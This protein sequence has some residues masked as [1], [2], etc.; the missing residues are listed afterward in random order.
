MKA[1]NIIVEST[2]LK[3]VLGVKLQME[4]TLVHVPGIL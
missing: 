1:G 3:P 4:K 2:K